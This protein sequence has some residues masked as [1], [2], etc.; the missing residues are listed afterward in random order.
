[1]TELEQA[2]LEEAMGEVKTYLRMG[3]LD[4]GMLNDIAF[5]YD[6]E[7]GVL[8]EA[9]GWGRDHYTKDK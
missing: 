5:N 1:M 2:E 9:L 3:A 7:P 6:L 8:L 4:E